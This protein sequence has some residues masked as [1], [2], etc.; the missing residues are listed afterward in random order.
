M[1]R[2]V[3]CLSF[4]C[5]LLGVGC[6]KQEETKNSTGR[7]ELPY[8]QTVE[9]YG[10]KG[11]LILNK[12]P[13]RVVTLSFTPVMALYE[14]GI[15]QVVVPVNRISRW[16]EELQKRAKQMNTG[17]ASN[18]DIE[19]VVSL[20]PDL[21]LLPYHSKDKYGKLLEKQNIPVY[22]VDAGPA[23]SYQSVKELIQVLATAFGS[24]TEAAGKIMERFTV[25]E[26]RM[27]KERE[28]NQ[29]KKVMILLSAPPHHY[30][31]GENTNLGSMLKMLGYTNVFQEQNVKNSMVLLDKEKALSYDPDV[32]VC[33]GMGTEAQHRSNMEK[34]FAGNPKYWQ[35]IR[36]F[37]EGKIVYLP[38]RYAIS[39][40]IGVTED[41]HELID[42][43]KR[44]K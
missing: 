6:A 19:A 37:C 24:K 38:A 44:I 25:L 30:I 27:T 11:K 36:A 32:V 42:V 7:I 34:D 10:I 13:E 4:L 22:Y 17:M 31:Q 5:L 39:S 41:I 12:K 16:P 9:K 35:H 26:A 14:M 18:V 8:T 23:M 21:V 1:K 28:S 29:G 20:H 40:G 3:I 15:P 43:L 2:I 33:V